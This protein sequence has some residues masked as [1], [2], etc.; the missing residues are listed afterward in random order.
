MI[1]TL[2]MVPL[3]IVNLTLVSGTLCSQTPSARAGAAMTYDGGHR[4]V[5]MFG[6]M[7]RD[8]EGRPLYPDDLWA[9]NGTTWHRVDPA[10][11][12]PWPIGRDAAMMVFDPSRGRVILLGGRRE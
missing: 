4:Q 3:A 9:W 5:L 12:T 11:G 2:R 1:S 7:A 10:P 8:A 6:G